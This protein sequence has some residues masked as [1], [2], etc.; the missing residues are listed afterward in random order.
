MWNGGWTEV[1]GCLGL[2]LALGFWSWR[3]RKGEVRRHSVL[4]V[5]VV[6]SYLQDI[7]V[8]EGYEVLLLVLRRD[9]GVCQRRCLGAGVG[10]RM[11]CWMVNVV[12]QWFLHDTR[13]A[14][15][16]QIW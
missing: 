15:H 6:L 1:R 3:A 9:G 16:F 5:V 12:C 10:V 11:R 13:V 7:L 4:T 2:F 8:W 14:D